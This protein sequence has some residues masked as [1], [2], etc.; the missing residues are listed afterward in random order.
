M[1][2]VHS[3]I[4]PLLSGNGNAWRNIFLYVLFYF[5][6]SFGEYISDV[7]RKWP[8]F[9]GFKVLKGVLKNVAIFWDAAPC[10]QHM[11]RRF[12][13]PYNLHLQGRKSV[14]Q[15][16][17]VQMVARWRWYLPPKRGYKCRLHGAISQNICTTTQNPIEVLSL[18]TCVPMTRRVIFSLGG[19]WSIIN[20]AFLA[21]K[22]YGPVFDELFEHSECA[23][24]RCSRKCG[25]NGAKAQYCLSP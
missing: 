22:V 8:V 14:E 23:L 25:G 10:I 1:A 18:Y 19:T 2:A 21:G 20:V 13:G 5:I 9:V 12:G 24:R 7:S 16:T 11:N 17:G 15:E 4:S 3:P 6:H